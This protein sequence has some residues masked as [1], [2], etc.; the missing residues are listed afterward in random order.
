MKQSHLRQHTKGNNQRIR[1]IRKQLD[2]KLRKLMWH[3]LNEN[4]KEIIIEELKTYL[5]T[6]ALK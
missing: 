4:E 2:L 1:L 6:G 3:N 5:K